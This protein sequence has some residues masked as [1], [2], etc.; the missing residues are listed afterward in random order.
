MVIDPLMGCSAH[1]QPVLYAIQHASNPTTGVMYLGGV[2]SAP[3]LN[4]GQLLVTGAGRVLGQKE[5]SQAKIFVTTVLFLR[6]GPFPGC[7][8]VF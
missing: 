2:T 4:V 1:G 8:L 5:F 6:P 7:R 3:D